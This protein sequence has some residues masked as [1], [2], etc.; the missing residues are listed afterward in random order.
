MMRKTS[1]AFHYHSIWQIDSGV[2]RS[3]SALGG[4]AIWAPLYKFVSKYILVQFHFD[5]IQ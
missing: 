2:G 3:V 4:W 1:I 5:Q